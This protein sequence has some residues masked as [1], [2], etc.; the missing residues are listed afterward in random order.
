MKRRE[1]DGGARIELTENPDVARETHEF[2]RK[3]SF[4]VGFALE[5]E[6]L[7]ERSREK[8]EEK[9][10]DLIVA[11]DVGSSSTDRPHR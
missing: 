6:D 2:R 1:A 10:F 9:E 3:G 8:L 7:L 11:N 4:T 5:T